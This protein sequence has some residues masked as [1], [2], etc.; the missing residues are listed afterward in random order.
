MTHLDLWAFNQTRNLQ[1][2]KLRT[3]K[4][5]KSSEWGPIYHCF[6]LFVEIS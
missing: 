2:F 1:R 5:Q 4:L 3:G 6:L